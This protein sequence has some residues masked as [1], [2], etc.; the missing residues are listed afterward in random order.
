MTSTDTV[1]VAGPVPT[2]PPAGRRR[3]VVRVAV[4]VVLATAGTLVLAVALAD[5]W[6]PQRW[7]YGGTDASNYF[8]NAAR[9]AEP[10]EPA[11]DFLPADWQLD[12]D[13]AEEVT[14]V[15]L[16][17]DGRMSK[18]ST[19]RDGRV[20][21][22]QYNLY[23]RLLQGAYDLDPDQLPWFVNY[24]LWAGLCVVLALLAQRLARSW[25]AAV[26][27]G[28]MVI[29]LPSYLLGARLTRTEALAAVLF[30]LFGLATVLTR[31][32]S[33]LP[34]LLLVPAWLTR[35]EFIVPLLIW[36]LWGVLRQKRGTA[37][38]VAA[39]IAASYLVPF[40]GRGQLFDTDR[41]LFAFLPAVGV[42]ILV[43][44]YALGAVVARRGH[45][46]IE[47]AARWLAG[48]GSKA[49]LHRA[50]WG[51]VLVAAVVFEAAR[52]GLEL[53]EHLGPIVGQRFSTLGLVVD[54]MGWPLAVVGAAGLVL[55]GPRLA[56]RAPLVLAAVTV[57]HAWV[58]VRLHASPSSPWSYTR[59]FHEALY[60]VLL[61]GVALVVAWVVEQLRAKAGSGR[62]VASGTLLVLAVVAVAA[63]VVPLRS[64]QPDVELSR[65]DADAFG[66][67]A[68]TLPEG[69]FVFMA[70]EFGGGK[71]QIP[72][73][74]QH[75]VW[76]F[77]V[78]A[79]GRFEAVA[80]ALLAEGSSPVY[81]EDR[82][83]PRIERRGMTCSPSPRWPAV[84]LPVRFSESSQDE[85]HLE[86]I[87][88]CVPTAAT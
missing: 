48:L 25:V 84:T 8:N 52:R 21:L 14:S 46:G 78:Y 57:P 59:R 64:Q 75:G 9:H 20:G 68:G 60:P 47:R 67:A 38:V 74:T 71:A 16:D 30:A 86:A 58:L 34:G 33:A 7:L 85:V 55:L 6:P 51:A 1:D 27:V 83:L 56:G 11:W 61:L 66:A 17:D 23:A 18:F 39:T 44:V 13:Q 62:A 31:G 80:E 87:R 49:W 19:V 72:L 15:L 41:D 12:D 69:S 2:S 79:P 32:Q 4:L 10:S 63:T 24:V 88:G 40:G 42:W 26:A 82:L 3:S 37:A 50:A 35:T 65:Y 54:S 5:V 43:P 28:I 77:V 73:R 81:L 29:A 36:I 45:D 76:S 53:Q 70:D 22:A